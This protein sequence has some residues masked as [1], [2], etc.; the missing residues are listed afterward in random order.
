MDL[1]LLRSVDVA[2]LFLFFF[3]CMCEC[4]PV[5]VCTSGMPGARQGQKRALDPPGTGVK[6]NGEMPCWCWELNPT[7]S[8]ARAGN[9]PKG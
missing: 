6:G 1:P 5:C 3:A 8:S 4:P 2:L 9:A 7:R